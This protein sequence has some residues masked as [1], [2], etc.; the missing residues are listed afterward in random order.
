MKVFQINRS[1]FFYL[2]TFL[3][4][5]VLTF[6]IGEILTKLFWKGQYPLAVDERNLNYAFDDELGWFPAKSTTKPFRAS[7]LI[8]V[9]NND[10]GFRDRDHG[11]KQKKR[12]AFLGDSFVWGYDVQEEERFTEKLQVL[13]PEWELINMGISGYGTDQE[14]MLIQKWFDHY[15][16]DII[17]LL[18]CENDK[19]NNMVNCNLEYYKPYYEVVNDTLVK[20]GVPVIKSINYYHLNYPLLF[21]SR[22]VS[23]LCKGFLRIVS[24]LHISENDPTDKIILSMKTYVEAKGARFILAFIDKPDFD[25]KRSFCESNK[26]EFLP[27]YTNDRFKNMGFHW[28]PSGHSFVCSR[29]FEYFMTRD[30]VLSSKDPVVSSGL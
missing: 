4:F 3:L 7:R 26:I 21:K 20:K 22:F 10:D 1:V 23:L 9:K 15:K 13:M 12:I 17:C 16:P 27:V 11:A 28:T 18:Y 25:E 14:F 30:S 29:L 6:S 24:P 2:I 5:I 19:R 8:N